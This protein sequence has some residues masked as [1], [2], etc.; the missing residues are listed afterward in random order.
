LS[1]RRAENVSEAEAE[2]SEGCPKRTLGSKTRP[3]LTSADNC[4]KVA[5]SRSSVEVVIGQKLS[6]QKI[7]L[8]LSWLSRANSARRACKYSRN[9]KYKIESLHMDAKVVT[10]V[11]R[12][13][14]KKGYGANADSV[15][16]CC[17]ASSISHSLFIKIYP[18]SSS[19]NHYNLRD[20]LRIHLL[21]QS[22][23][24][25]QTSIPRRNAD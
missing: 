13:R 7:W 14:R 16:V 18:H 12:N 3:Q 19:V 1:R 23:G 6:L 17:S 15:E 20:P 9:A 22:S 4:P 11:W 2:L 8:G 25:G 21:S 10:P 5:R 24:P